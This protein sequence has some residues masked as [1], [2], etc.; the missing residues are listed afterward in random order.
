MSMADAAEDDKHK[1]WE[2]RSKGLNYLVVAHAA[3]LI[4]CLTALK[5]YN[6]M[7]QL[8]G[9]GWLVW[10]FGLGLMSAIVAVFFLTRWR[11]AELRGNAMQESDKMGF[12]YPAVLSTGLLLVA[13]VVAIVKFG[14]L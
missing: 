2:V 13:I 10:L 1:L 12:G 3:G 9:V 6:T 5:D 11:Q 14:R 7:P 8:K 4:A